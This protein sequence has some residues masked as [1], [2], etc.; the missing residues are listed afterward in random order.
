MQKLVE[1]IE[2]KIIAMQ[3]P[4][5]FIAKILSE[6]PDIEIEYM[7]QRIKKEQIL[8]NNNLLIGYKR[9]FDI[10]ESTIKIK[11][12]NGTSTEQAANHTHLLKK[13]SGDGSADLTGVIELKN[14]LKKG[15]LVLVQSVLNSYV[16]V[17]SV[18]QMPGK[19]GEGA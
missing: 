17:C 18:E 10:K 4:S 16:I 5:C 13:I 9:N 14:T 11:I 3:N 6:P 15:Q 7:G 2:K 19:A 1:A 12:N 8:I